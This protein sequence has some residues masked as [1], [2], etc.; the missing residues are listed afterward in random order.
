[1]QEWIHDLPDH[2][3]YLDKVGRERLETLVEGRERR[4]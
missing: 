1:M 4:E 3:A 2:Q